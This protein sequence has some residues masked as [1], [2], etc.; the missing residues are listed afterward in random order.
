MK[1]LISYLN[2]IKTKHDIKS[3]LQ[4]A[5]LIGVSAAGIDGIM[6]GR[7]NPSDERCELIAQLAEERPEVIIAIV[8]AKKAKQ[9][10]K[11]YWDKILKAVMAASFVLLFTL[12]AFATQQNLDNS[13]SVYYVKL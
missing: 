2:A 7:I 5:A 10:Q 11:K 8:H 4:L 9:G 13:F 1:D 3:N 6:K 12:P